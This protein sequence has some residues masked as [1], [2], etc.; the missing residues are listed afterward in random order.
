MRILWLTSIDGTCDGAAIVAGTEADIG[1][2]SAVDFISKGMAEAVRS[3]VVEAAVKAA[4]EN[5]AKR[6]TKPAPKK[7]A[8]P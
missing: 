4:P 7:G 2:A 1:D 3:H 8:K 6:T 5:T